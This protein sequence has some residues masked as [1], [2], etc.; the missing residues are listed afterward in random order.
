MENSKENTSIKP[1]L[2][3]KAMENTSTTKY[4]LCVLLMFYLIKQL[5][6]LITYKNV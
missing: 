1:L 5:P 2:N 6:S 4:S 3:Q